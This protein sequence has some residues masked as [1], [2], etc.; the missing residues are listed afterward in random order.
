MSDE[1]GWYH[2]LSEWRTLSSSLS[3]RLTSIPAATTIDQQRVIASDCEQ[4]IDEIQTL[5]SGIEPELRHYPYALSRKATQ[6][7][8]E[9]RETFDTQTALFRRYQTSVAAGKLVQKDDASIRSGA[10]GVGA[11]GQPAASYV[12]QRAMLLDAKDMLSEGDSSLDNT[13]RMLLETTAIGTETTAQLLAQRE[14]FENQRDVLDETD[15]FLVRSSKTLRRMGRRVITNK[16]VSGLII[17]LLIASFILGG[18]IKYYVIKV[19]ACEVCQ[20]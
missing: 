11:R 9:F 13:N 20:D 2:F 15:T 7:M 16:L 18:Y 14:Q 4:T 10:V 1:Q 5:I 12:D 19:K 6:Q 17:V 8:S 3:A